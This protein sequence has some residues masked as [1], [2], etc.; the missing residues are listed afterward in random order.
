MQRKRA[1]VA[2]VVSSVTVASQTWVVRP[3]WVRVASQAMAPVRAVPRK[4][5]LSSMVVKF[6]MPSGRLR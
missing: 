3:P 2:P 6:S 5:V 1:M 4:L